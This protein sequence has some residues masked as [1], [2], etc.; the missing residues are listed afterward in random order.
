MFLVRLD[1]VSLAFGARK[2]LRHA[3]LSI[4]PGE[5]VCLVGRNGAGKTSLL[6]LV[7]GELEPDEGEVRRQGDLCISELAQ[8]LPADEQGRVGEFVSVGLADI[9][10]LTRQYR[11]Q[12]EATLD[13]RGLAALQDLHSHI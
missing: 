11:E 8:V 4:E 6:H 1:S 13:K 2:L 3:E 10:A 7:K 12:A 9:I 5:R